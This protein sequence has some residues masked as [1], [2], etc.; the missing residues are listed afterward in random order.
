MGMAESSITYRHP[1]RGGQLLRTSAD[2]RGVVL[3]THHC[4]WQQSVSSCP[5]VP[6]RSSLQL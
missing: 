4:E 1:P 6:S 5:T 2:L 3:D